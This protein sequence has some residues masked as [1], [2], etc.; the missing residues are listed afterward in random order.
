MHLGEKGLRVV[1]AGGWVAGRPGGLAIIP[2]VPWV[3][4]TRLG[5]H[6]GKGPCSDPCGP[7]PGRLLLIACRTP[8]LLPSF[9]SHRPAGLSV[10]RCGVPLSPPTCWSVC[11]GPQAP[12][13]PVLPYSLWTPLLTVCLGLLASSGARLFSSWLSAS[14]PAP[15]FASPFP[16]SVS[17]GCAS[18]SF[19]IPLSR[20]FFHF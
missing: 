13:G 3:W 7:G 8:L 6:V 16:L 15:K 20:S 18:V 5:P 9:P 19:S 2:S 14:A 1:E 4:K 10:L 11:P 12:W 17:A